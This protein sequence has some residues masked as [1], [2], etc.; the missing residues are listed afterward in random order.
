M[1]P[2]H[3]MCKNKLKLQYNRITAMQCVKSALLIAYKVKYTKQLVSSM[4]NHRIDS[5]LVIAQWSYASYR[6]SIFAII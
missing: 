2:F 4:F 3:N 6:I 1:D 5:I